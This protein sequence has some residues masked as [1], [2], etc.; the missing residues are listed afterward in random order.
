[1]KDLRRIIKSVVRGYLV[2]STNDNKI[3]YHG[4]DIVITQKDLKPKL[5]Y[6]TDNYDEAVA[7]SVYKHNISNPNVISANLIMN[8]ILRDKKILHLIAEKKG[9]NV[10]NYYS[11]A[12]LVEQP[13]IVDEL[14]KLG[15]DS[16]IFSDFGFLSD[17]EEFNAHIVFNAKKQVKIIVDDLL[18]NQN[19]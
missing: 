8:N 14:E 1:M 5:M 9:Y 12:E 6:F 10:Y 7:Y 4:S 11:D 15:Y 13:G 17:F 2:E 3:F 18:Q 16:A 19:N